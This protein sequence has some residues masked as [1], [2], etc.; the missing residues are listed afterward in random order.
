MEKAYKSDIPSKTNHGF[1]EG[2]VGLMG[3]V[4]GFFGSIPFCFVCVF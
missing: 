1:Y 3:E 2:M 4:M